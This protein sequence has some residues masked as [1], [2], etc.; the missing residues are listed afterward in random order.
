MSEIKDEPRSQSGDLRMYQIS[1][2]ITKVKYQ[3]LRGGLRTIQYDSGDFQRES[4]LASKNN[5][6]KNA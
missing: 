3:G 4:L 2:N 1:D 6:G 5:Q